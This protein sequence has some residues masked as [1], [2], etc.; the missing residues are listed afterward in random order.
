[1][2]TGTTGKSMNQLFNSCKKCLS[3]KVIVFVIVGVVIL[4]IFVPLIGVVS[5]VAAAP[6]IGC[7]FMCGAMALFMRGE[8]KGNNK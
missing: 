2:P 8:K 7:V 4:L 1:M 6:L 3:P 5:L